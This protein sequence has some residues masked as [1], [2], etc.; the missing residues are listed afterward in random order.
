MLQQNLLNESIRY[1]TQILKVSF[2]VPPHWHTE[3]EVQ[4][5]LSGGFSANID[6]QMYTVEKGQVL[7]ISCFQPHNYFNILPDTRVL[8]IAFGPALLQSGFT[9]FSKK[10]FRHPLMSDAMPFEKARR[11]FE[12]IRQIMHAIIN[13]IGEE[14]YLSSEFY[15]T[16]NVDN[17]RAP[18]SEWKIRGCLLILASL[19]S[20]EL[21]YT[22]PLARHRSHQLNSA[23]RIQ[24]AIS[25]IHTK[26]ADNLTVEDAQKVTGYSKSNFHQQF[27][28]ATGMSFH[29]YLNFFRINTA[30]S[31]LQNHEKS[32]SSVATA[33]GFLELKTFCRQFKI[34]TGLT[35]SEYRKIN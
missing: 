2:N 25:L 30:C 9:E 13:E 28:L 14:K 8:Y 35:P 27:K 31:L 32:I 3:L 4:Y 19:F 23:L 15:Q 5:V 34:H 29:A 7:L 26:Y 21:L 11:V 6:S 24:E 33:V 20:R 22:E 12:E 16:V 17:D 10:I 1:E 18:D